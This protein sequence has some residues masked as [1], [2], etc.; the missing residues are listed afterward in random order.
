MLFYKVRKLFLQEKDQNNQ[1]FNTTIQVAFL[2]SVHQ[3]LSNL[4]I[5]SYIHC[6]TANDKV[7]PVQTD[8]ISQQAELHHF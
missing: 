2:T 5:S 3:Y 6:D 8:E 1:S 4:N 7:T